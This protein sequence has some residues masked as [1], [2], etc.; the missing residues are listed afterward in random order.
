MPNV[1]NGN[2]AAPRVHGSY[3]GLDL[4]DVRQPTVTLDL[5]PPYGA[6]GNL[7]GA[8]A[9]LRTARHAY[10]GDREPFVYPVVL[11]FPDACV[12]VPSA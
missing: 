7:S 2:T 10:R 12:D 1:R 11:G 9:A 4:L 5:G 3:I 6:Y 8:M